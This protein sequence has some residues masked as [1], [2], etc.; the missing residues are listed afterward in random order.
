FVALVEAGKD[1]DLVADFGIGGEVFGLDA[2]PA[3]PL[4]GLALGG[5]ILGLDAFVHQPGG[6]QGNG[7]AKLG[8]C[9]PFVRRYWQP[10]VGGAGLWKDGKWTPLGGATPLFFP[11]SP[12]CQGGMKKAR[13]GCRGPSITNRS[14]GVTWRGPSPGRPDRPWAGPRDRRRRR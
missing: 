5:E 13:G 10:I 14:Q 11:P 8:I 4:G 1:L 9:H 12:A 7:L 3:Q 2:A 6:F